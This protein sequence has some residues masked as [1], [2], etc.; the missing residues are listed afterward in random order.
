MKIVLFIALESEL[1]RDIIRTIP[2]DI[3]PFYTGVGK[4]NAAMVSSDILRYYNPTDTMVINFGSAGAPSDFIHTLVKC[5]MFRQGDMNTEPLFPIGETPFDMDLYNWNTKEINTHSGGFVC[6]TSDTFNTS[7]TT[8]VDMEAYSI[9][10][11]CKRLGF[12]FVSYKWISDS[13]DVNDWTENHNKGI[14]E[15]INTLT[16]LK[17]E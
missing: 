8:I 7:P 17:Y 15:F 14:D 10:K 6:T 16:K 13:G 11:V 1:P 5:S 9:A 2:L 4:V 12:S 3:H